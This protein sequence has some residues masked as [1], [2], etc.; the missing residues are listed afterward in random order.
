MT[1][2]D[3]RG[4]GEL[5]RRRHRLADIVVERG[6]VQVEELVAE[7]GV[8]AMTV[9]RDLAA[10]EQLG[11]LARSR[12][13]VTS[14]VTSLVEASAAY[15]LARDTEVKDELGAVA[16]RLVAPDSVLMLDDS[17][18]GLHVLRALGATSG[19]TVITHCQFVATAAQAMEGVRLHMVG[20]RWTPWAQAYHGPSTVAALRE[21]SADCCVMSATAIWD[22]AM[23]HPDGDVT[24]VK[25]AMLA[26]SVR[27]ILVVD[28]SK[29]SRRAMHRVADLAQVDDVVVPSALSAERVEHLRDLGL[30]VHVS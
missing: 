18:T 13:T 15:R 7:L 21:L 19:L 14:V 9:Y 11:L 28:S 24:E 27:K 22:D 17:T 6:S 26:R 20:G 8:S 16:A 2:E 23:H 5:N 10:L 12:G 30:R 25:R 4:A 3:A 1:Q 29:F